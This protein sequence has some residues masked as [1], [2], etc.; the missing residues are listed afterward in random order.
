[1]TQSK[2]GGK[3]AEAAEAT[4]LETPAK[5]QL[6]ELNVYPPPE[7]NRKRGIECLEAEEANSNPCGIQSM[8]SLPLLKV[9][10]DDVPELRVQLD[11]LDDFGEFEVQDS[12]EDEKV[13]PTTKPR[14]TDKAQIY[15]LQGVHD[16]EELKHVKK[17][18]EICLKKL[19]DEGHVTNPLSEI[20]NKLNF[21]LFFK[22]YKDV[23]YT[24]IVKYQRL[25]PRLNI[26]LD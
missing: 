11:T 17:F 16:P 22:M 26:R 14:E 21:D 20:Y 24:S 19:I 12:E 6:D 5:L 8:Q 7:S 3:S 9:D 2:S 10:E 25:A 13:S 15:K 1:M 4:L 18:V 23:L